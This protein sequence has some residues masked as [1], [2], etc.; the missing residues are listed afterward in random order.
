M[1]FATRPS[2]EVTNSKEERR[3][4]A[5]RCREKP[6]GMAGGPEDSG[7]YSSQAVYP[8]EICLLSQLCGNGARLFGLQAG[9]VFD[10]EFSPSR[11]R[12]VQRML[13]G[14]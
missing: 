8:L 12:E 5:G 7:R 9:D 3:S 6:A 1:Y 4:S 10:C 11:F 14:S 13:E 2:L